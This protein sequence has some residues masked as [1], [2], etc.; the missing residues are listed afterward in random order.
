MA[1]WFWINLIPTLCIKKNDFFTFKMISPLFCTCKSSINL[2][3][4]KNKNNSQKELSSAPLSNIVFCWPCF[5]TISFSNLY[6]TYLKAACYMFYYGC[7]E[8]QKL[9]I[10]TMLYCYCRKAKS[11]FYFKVLQMFVMICSIL[12]LWHHVP[13]YFRKNNT[14][15]NMWKSGKFHEKIDIF[16]NNYSIKVWIQK[17]YCTYVTHITVI[18]IRIRYFVFVSESVL[19]RL[20]FWSI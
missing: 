11:Y 2:F 4:I 3:V 14:F 20:S 13:F 7:R 8:R 17:S 10:V 16:V 19:V 6:K 9:F 18:V 15:V 1:I 12:L 5:Q